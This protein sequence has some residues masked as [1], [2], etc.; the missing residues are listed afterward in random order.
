MSFGSTSP[1]PAPNPTYVANAQTQSNISVAI[2]N[3]YLS[4]ANVVSPQGSS[5][6]AQT[7]TFT[8]SDPQYNAGLLVST[9]DRDIPIF[10]QTVT[11]TTKGQAIYD[12]SQD[13][14]LSLNTLGAE[15]LTFLATPP[16]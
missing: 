16:A 7:G 3:S 6:F 15:Q 1:P 8:L 11:L 12:K 2:A 13:M 10:T 4:N 14:Q 9:T 5:T